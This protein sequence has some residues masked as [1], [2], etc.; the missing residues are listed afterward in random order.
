MCTPQPTASTRPHP[1]LI[2]FGFS[3]QLQGLAALCLSS[4]PPACPVLS[5]PTARKV[6]TI[7]S[8]SPTLSRDPSCVPWLKPRSCEP[9]GGSLEAGQ[10]L[11]PAC[12]SPLRRRAP[13]G[14]EWRWPKAGADR[15]ARAVSLRSPRP[16]CPGLSGSQ[17]RH[18]E[19]SRCRDGVEGSSLNP[20]GSPVAALIGVS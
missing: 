17:R 2:W 3:H 6:P 7:A 12:S 4:S 19:R 20:L 15:S 11:L 14:S 9:G 5:P 18:R 8:P 13:T 16:P 1:S 10:P